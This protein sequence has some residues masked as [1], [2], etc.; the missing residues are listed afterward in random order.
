[1]RPDEVRKLTDT[2]GVLACALVIGANGPFEG[3]QHVGMILEG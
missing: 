2:H 1:L 3:I